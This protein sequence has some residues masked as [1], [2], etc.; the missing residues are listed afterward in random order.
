MNWCYPSN[1]IVSYAGKFLFL[2][3]ILVKPHEIFKEARSMEIVVQ[4]V[5]QDSE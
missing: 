3:I 5:L 4:K 2:A 1:G